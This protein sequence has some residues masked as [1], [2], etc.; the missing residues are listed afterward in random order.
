MTELQNDGITEL[1]KDRQGK[2]S[3]APTFSKQGY[4]YGWNILSVSYLNMKFQN[5]SLGD[6]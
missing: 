1:Q 5:F 4:K 3:I 6:S 2:S